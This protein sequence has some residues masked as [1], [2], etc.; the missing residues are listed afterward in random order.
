MG[1]RLGE[2]PRRKHGLRML[3]RVDIQTGLR[4]RWMEN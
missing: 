2:G 4:N 3:E 1:S